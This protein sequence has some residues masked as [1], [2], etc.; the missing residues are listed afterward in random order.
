MIFI[1][2]KYVNTF[3]KSVPSP[4]HFFLATFCSDGS[5]PLIIQLIQFAFI[6]FINKHFLVSTVFFWLEF[7]VYVYL[8]VCLSFII[9]CPAFFVNSSWVTLTKQWDVSTVGIRIPH[10]SGIRKV[11]IRLVMKWSGNRIPFYNWTSK[12]PVFG[13]WLCKV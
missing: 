6:F 11:G 2:Y 12:R 3:N 5:A 10:V 1:Y 13:S 9:F 8:S 7:F 4:V